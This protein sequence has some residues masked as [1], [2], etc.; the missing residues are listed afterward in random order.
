MRPSVGDGHIGIE[1]QSQAMQVDMVQQE[2][3]AS[4]ES[5]H[6]G[7]VRAS[8]YCEP[9]TSCAQALKLLEC[10]LQL[11]E[12][13]QHTRCR[14]AVLEA[15]RLQFAVLMETPQ[16]GREIGCWDFRFSS[17]HSEKKHWKRDTCIREVMSNAVSAKVGTN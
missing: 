15:R 10:R 6:I 12:M 16:V 13:L 7:S 11:R 9:F 8:C 14:S 17:A 5:N 1:V 4:S 2:V 3:L